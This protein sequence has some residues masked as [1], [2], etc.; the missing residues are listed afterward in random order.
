MPSFATSLV[1]R[2]HAWTLKMSRSGDIV[3]ML[4]DGDSTTSFAVIVDQ[5]DETMS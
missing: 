3:I 4:C 2:G 5:V 1:D